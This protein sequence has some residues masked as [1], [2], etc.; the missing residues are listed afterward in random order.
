LKEEQIGDDR[1]YILGGGE[2]PHI[3]AVVIREPE[4]GGQ[5]IILGTHKDHLVLEPLAKKACT[6]YGV[7]TLA[8]GG[9]H[10]DDASPEEIEIIMKNCKELMECI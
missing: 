6:K 1:L 2:T 10:I 9:I 5:T 3:G 7:T 4:K 8:V